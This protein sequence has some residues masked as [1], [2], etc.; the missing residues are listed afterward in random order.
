VPVCRISQ[1]NQRPS[2]ANNADGFGKR[3]RDRI[4]QEIAEIG[5]LIQ[6]EEELGNVCSRP[7]HGLLPEMRLDVTVAFK[8]ARHDIF[9]AA[10]ERRIYLLVHPFLSI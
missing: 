10:N 6:N 8:K 3:T 7:G 4:T 5:G 2:A 1:Q 9:T